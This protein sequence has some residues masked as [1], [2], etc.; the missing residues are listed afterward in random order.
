MSS[1]PAKPNHATRIIAGVLLVSVVLWAHYYMPGQISALT[2]EAIRSLHGPGF[3][4]VAL[5]VVKLGRF[6][7]GPAARYIKA[8]ATTMLLA[9]LAEAAQIPG[10][11][12]AELGD[13][14]IDALGIIGFLGLAAAFDHDL[15][16]KVGT[17]GTVAIVLVSLPAFAAAVAPTAWLSYALVKR[18]QA[19]PQLLSFDA[20]W[21]QTYA[22]GNAVDYDVVPAPA[23]WPAGSGNIARLH[24]AGK[25]G[26][27]LH[28]RPYPDWS[29]YVAVSFIAATTGGETR[30]IALGLWGLNLGDGTLPGRYYTRAKISPIPARYCILFE[31][32]PDRSSERPFNLHYVSQLTVGATKN[33]R[34]VTVYVDDFRLERSR[35]DCSL[36]G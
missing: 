26:L 34:G 3:G 31:E 17:L 2:A 29:N 7:G 15:R 24:S 5:V 14:L 23:N 25:S 18:N 30:R 6:S 16:S 10:S 1:D 21:E 8:G 28:I 33:E 11:R 9:I 20:A 19:L 36:E 13:L 12:E 32:L 35:D 27:M 22:S 4:I